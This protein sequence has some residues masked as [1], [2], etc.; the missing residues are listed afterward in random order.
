MSKFPLLEQLRAERQRQEDEIAEP[1]RY[2]IDRLDRRVSELAASLRTLERIVGSEIGKYAVEQIGHE[3]GNELRR[4]ILDAI[5]RA[6]HS[7]SRSWSVT[8]PT[9]M[10]RFMDPKSLET[11]ILKRYAYEN[12][13]KLSLRADVRPQDRVTVLDIRIPELGYRRAMAEFN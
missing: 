7:E 8:L 11:E 6:F 1:L 12:M 5:P 9:D 2:V 10:L 4:I 13:P 3:I